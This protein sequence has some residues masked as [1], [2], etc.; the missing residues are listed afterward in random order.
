MQPAS[1]NWRVTG[2]RLLDSTQV[3]RDLA[4]WVV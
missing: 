1:K 3:D 4:A 2:L